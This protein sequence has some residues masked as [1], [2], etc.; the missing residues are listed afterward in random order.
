MKCRSPES[1]VSG[2]IRKREKDMLLR[3]VRVEKRKSRFGQRGAERFTKKKKVS[4]KNMHL[5]G[6][7]FETRHAKG[8]CGRGKNVCGILVR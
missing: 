6:K 5:V 4:Q 2:V 8:H 1:Q 7:V 3:H